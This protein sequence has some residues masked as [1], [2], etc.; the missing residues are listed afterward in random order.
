MM[1]PVVG[2]LDDKSKTKNNLNIHYVIPN[3]M[4][5]LEV[6]LIVWRM[7][8]KAAHHIRYTCKSLIFHCYILSSDYTKYKCQPAG[9]IGF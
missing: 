9:G 8:K 3:I 1:S 6:I 4:G 2:F 7:C 5:L